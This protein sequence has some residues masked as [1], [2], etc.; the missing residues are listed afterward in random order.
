MLSNIQKFR[1]SNALFQ[2]YV[3]AYLKCMLSLERVLK[4]N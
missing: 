1:H 3:N 2:M 4:W